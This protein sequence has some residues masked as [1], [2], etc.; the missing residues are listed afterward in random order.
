MALLLVACCGCF[1]RL[2]HGL[3]IIVMGRCLCVTDLSKQKGVTLRQGLVP[4]VRS[5]S[6]DLPFPFH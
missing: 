6:L 4:L 1:D 5:I 2:G 3:R